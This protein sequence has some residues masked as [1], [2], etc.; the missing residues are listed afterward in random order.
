M[1]YQ[2]IPFSSMWGAD[3]GPADG[4]EPCWVHAEEDVP[5]T[6]AGEVANS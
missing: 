6:D 1:S 5:A 3:T 2:H 4:K